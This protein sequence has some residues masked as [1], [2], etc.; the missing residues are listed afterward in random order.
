MDFPP[1]HTLE[2]LTSSEYERDFLRLEF[3]PGL[4]YYLDR[5][6]QIQFAGDAVLDAGCGAGQWSIALSQRFGRVAA[7]DQKPDRLATLDRVAREMAILHIDIRQGSVEKLPYPDQR[8]DAVFC[9]G[10]IM[11]TRVPEV[12]REFFR[13]LRPCGRAYICLNADGWSYYLIH[14][15]GRNN[16]ALRAAGQ[17]TL[18]NTFG[19]RAH[20]FVDSAQ[21]RLRW[22]P[23]RLLKVVGRFGYSRRLVARTLLTG[24]SAGRRLT[25]AIGDLGGQPLLD[26]WYRDIGDALFGADLRAR[27]GVDRAYEPE[28]FETI[29][30]Q[31]GFGDF[32]WA[33]E[34][35]LQC[36]W[37]KPPPPAKYAG[38]H[39]GRLSV[40]ECLLTRPQLT[41]GLA[42]MNGR[43]AQVADEKRESIAQANPNFHYDLAGAA[44]NQPVYLEP[45]LQPILSSGSRDTFPLARLE[46]A[47]SRAASVGG[48]QYLRDL[49]KRLLEGAAGEEDV[50]RRVMCFVQRAIFR[51]AI[52]QPLEKCSALPDAATILFCARG[53][54]GHCAVVVTELMGLAGF[55]SRMTQLKKH[56]I[57]EVKIH[58]R[59]V[60]ADADAF[61][62]G[63]L[64]LNRSGALISLEDLQG[65][66]YQIDRFPATGWFIR[67]RSRYIRGIRGL[68]VTGYV[69]ALEP[70]DRGFVSGYYVM[71]AWGHPP[72]LPDGLALRVAGGGL[73]LSWKPSTSKTDR[74]LGYRV[75]VGTRSRGWTYDQLP[76]D[77]TLV[78]PLPADVLGVFTTETT[79]FA[80]IPSQARCLY[81]SVTAITSRIDLEPETYFHPSEELRHEL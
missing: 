25:N 33:A 27:L 36:R 41:D 78:Q 39:G 1:A 2:A 63:V 28:E 56:I 49:V 23:G 66:P 15:R 68:R 59:W 42:I 75:A 20:V 24:S 81:A 7:L 9:Y 13:V 19:H 22:L 48:K 73:E 72:S 64:P 10:V 74:V 50:F 26:R 17:G 18:Y 21:Q 30:G 61:K 76:L 44:S 80:A 32:Q 5:L 54:C 57:A 60:I 3:G 35:G 62:N 34:G 16:R 6:D 55:E 69:D 53:R 38:Y 31:A 14:E 45:C 43:Y 70:E 29:A 4:Q 8:F 65:D 71:R 40:W 51:D 52:S 12:L 58:G 77:E 37:T 11:F 46:R 47:K 79:A 67:P